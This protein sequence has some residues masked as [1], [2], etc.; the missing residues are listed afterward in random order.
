MAKPLTLKQK[1]FAKELALHGNGTRAALAAGYAN[2]SGIRVTASRQLTKANV[3]KAFADEV[4]AIERDFSPDRVRRRLD[5]ISHAAERDGAYGPAVRAEE[6][7]GKAA[8]MWIDQSLS[9]SGVLSDTHVAALVDYAKR[10]QLQPVDNRDREA[11]S[12][13]DD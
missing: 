1:R 12:D 11:D 5:Q 10:R 4:A 8:G 13:D 6:L 9:L 7:I 3:Q 2:G